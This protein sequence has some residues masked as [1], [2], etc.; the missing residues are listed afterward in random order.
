MPIMIRLNNHCKKINFAS[1]IFMELL[2][3]KTTTTST[4]SKLNEW[5]LA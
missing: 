5:H 4:V 3:T 2:T 1:N